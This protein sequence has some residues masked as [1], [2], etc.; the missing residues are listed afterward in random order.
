MFTY[1][2]V[3]RIKNLKSKIMKQIMFIIGFLLS[4]FLLFSSFSLR[5]TPQDPPRG[6]KG[7]KAQRHIRLEKI[8]NGEKTVLD[9]VIEGNRIFVWNGDTIGSGEKF[10]WFGTDDFDLDSLTEN[11]EFRFFESDEKGGKQFVFAPH[12][13]HP[14]KAPHVVKLNKNLQGNVID[15]SSSGIISYKKKKLSGG[16][17][18]ITII[19]NEPS[20]KEIDKNVVVTIPEMPEPPVWMSADGSE[21]IETIKVIK[22]SDG[23]MEIT[24]DEDVKIL[25]KDGK[26]KIL[27][28]KVE[29]GTENVEI[30]MEENE[31][32]DMPG[33]N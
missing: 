4:S 23:E 8:E 28:K 24:E 16:R 10:E 27:R 26:V 3:V 31:E 6:E 20:E 9:T 19:R 13:P 30:E 17:E 2:C 1:L 21:K 22:K 25:R 18:K 14:P 7:E 5:E 12:P 11:F 15:L 33:N 29:D 32:N